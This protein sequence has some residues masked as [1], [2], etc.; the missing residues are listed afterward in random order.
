ME[1][2]EQI[3][4]GIK[5]INLENE[6]GQKLKLEILDYE[7]PNIEDLGGP[8]TQAQMEELEI[9]RDYDANWLNVQITAENQTTKW[10]VVD[11]CMLTW[12]LENLLTWFVNMA[13]DIET[14]NLATSL[15]F[16]E[17]CITLYQMRL[18]DD[19]YRIRFALSFELAPPNE[20]RGAEYYMDFNLSRKE[21]AVLADNIA[22]ALSKYPPR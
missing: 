5:M 14:E 2:F 9:D 12:E 4:G 3:S 21:I 13:E 17:P 15:F 18:D 10:D 11:P 20:A 6:N 7:F 1:L 19:N 22:V 16:I 8:M